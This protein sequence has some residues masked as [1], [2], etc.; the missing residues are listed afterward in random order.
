MLQEDK[1]Q[2]KI[3]IVKVRKNLR[4]KSLKVLLISNAKILLPQRTI[5][6]GNSINNGRQNF[7]AKA[8]LGL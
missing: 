1:I 4:Y 7:K 2:I 5:T 8:H 3:Q 6:G